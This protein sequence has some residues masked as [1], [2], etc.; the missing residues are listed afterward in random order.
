MQNQPETEVEASAVHEITERLNTISNT[1]KL[2]KRKA[3]FG[4]FAGVACALSGMILVPILL[5]RDD[6]LGSKLAPLLMFVGLMLVALSASYPS[7]VAPKFNPEEAARLGGVQAIPVLFAALQHAG[8]R[9]QIALIHKA[10]SMLLPQMKSSDAHLLTPASHLFINTWLSSLSGNVS[11]FR[12]TDEVRLASLKAL[13][14]VGDSSAIPVVEK[15]AKS[16]ARN[17]AQEKIKQAA[18]EC[19]PMLQD[20][21]GKVEANKTLLRA[22]H[23]P[24]AAPETLLRPAE[25]IPDAAPQQLLR[26]SHSSD[27]TPPAD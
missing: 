24:A 1:I 21:C 27:N 3:I 22:S 20:N 7:M 26:A 13:E 18:I 9:P 11:M 23:A 25:S 17:T 2:A 14:Q 8:G 10:L 4:Y 19:L 15:L 6:L 16:K 5:G 12:Y